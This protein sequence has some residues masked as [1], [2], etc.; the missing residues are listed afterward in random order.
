LYVV[1]ALL[2]ASSTPLSAQTIRGVVSASPDGRPLENASITLL[3]QRGRDLGKRAVRSDSSGHFTI[4]AGE[5]G[6]YM[7]RAIRIGYAPAT[8]GAISLLLGAQVANVT[9]H[10]SPDTTKLSTVVVTGTTRLNMY[11]LMSDVGL[12]FA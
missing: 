3:D 9:L 10:M 5:T 1:R 6:T 12:T 8:S 11:E 4:H 7:I 2:L